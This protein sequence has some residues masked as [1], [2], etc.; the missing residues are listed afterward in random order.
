MSEVTVRDLRNHSAEV[1]RRV[2]RGERLIVTKDGEAVAQ[3]IPLP[4]RTSRV[5]ELVERRRHLPQVN[6]ARLLA[7]I[8]Q[9]LD[10]TL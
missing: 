8:D 5:E 1:L 10:P 6:P 9:W 2:S 4:R 3:V 7:D